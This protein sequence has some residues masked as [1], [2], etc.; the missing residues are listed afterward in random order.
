MTAVF[1]HFMPPPLRKEGKHHLPW[2]VHTCNKSGCHE[3]KHVQFRTLSGFETCEG[4]PAEQTCACTVSNHHLRGYGKV[5]WEG[6]VAIIECDG[7]DDGEALINGAAY[8][9]DAKKSGEALEKAKDQI[10]RLKERRSTE[11]AAAEELRKKLA[12]TEKAKADLEDGPVRQLGIQK[13]KYT[14]LDGQYKALLTKHQALKAEFGE[15]EQQHYRLQSSLGGEQQEQQQ[16]GDE[17][18]APSSPPKRRRSRRAMA[19]HSR[20]SEP[21]DG[22][23]DDEDAA[24]E[25]PKPAEACAEASAAAAEVH[26]P[27]PLPLRSAP[28]SGVSGIT[29]EQRCT[30]SVGLRSLMRSSAQQVWVLTTS[31]GERRRG[32]TVSSIVLCSLEPPMISFNL[33]R[34][35]AIEQLLLCGDVDTP[36]PAAAAAAEGARVADATARP[37]GSPPLPPPPMPMPRGRPFVAHL[38]SSAGQR[39]AARFAQRG[40][41]DEQQFESLTWHRAGSCGQP[42]L[43]A[44]GPSDPI[45]SDCIHC[46]PSGPGG[47][48]AAAGHTSACA[49]CTV[50]TFAMSPR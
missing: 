31:D 23:N 22:T 41:S 13:I 44:S 48:S 8:R 18:S 45:H 47:V 5:R 14:V 37:D 28:P 50:C 1:V 7:E 43:C 32:A 29:A 17:N 10:K 27:P 2:I 9:D 49:V 24:D 26:P 46:G 3:A 11:Q 6:E 30:A 42:V 15:Q 34:H 21:D 12:A 4:A 20:A 25:P 33:R 38:L 16:H 19:R 36:A 39:L 35:S 40:L